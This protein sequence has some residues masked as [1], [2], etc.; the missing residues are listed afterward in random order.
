VQR[1]ALET[2]APPF[3]RVALVLATHD[4][5]D[6]FDPAAVWRHLDHNEYAVFV[7]T[8]RAVQRVKVTPS[9]AAIEER[10]YGTLPAE[11]QRAKFAVEGIDLDVLNLHHGRQRDPPVANVGFLIDI[12]GFRVVHLGDTEVPVEELLDYGLAQESI[13][14]AFVP[15]WQLMGDDGKRLVEEAL[16]PRY[17]VAM[18]IPAGNASASYF[19]PATSL[20]D[21][22]NQLREV[23]PG[24]IIL[25]DPFDTVKIAAR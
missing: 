23:H 16:N 7:S 8:P 13:D 17:V 22:V 25:Q 24:V 14:V 19:E 12:E 6:H 9:T 2:A 5:A 15:Y 4:H 20:G 10:L 3:D 11:G 18:H 21:L 1:E